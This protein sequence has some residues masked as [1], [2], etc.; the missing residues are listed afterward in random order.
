M[1]QQEKLLWRLSGITKSP[2]QSTKRRRRP[3]LS[4][5]YC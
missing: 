2:A 4:F 3:Q 1:P 5:F